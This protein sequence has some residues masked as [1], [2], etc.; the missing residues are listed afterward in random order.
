MNWATCTNSS[1][2]LGLFCWV[3]RGERGGGGEGGKGKAEMGKGD[4]EQP[5]D[6]VAG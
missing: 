5:G 1:G 6:G 3:L 2:S 4:D